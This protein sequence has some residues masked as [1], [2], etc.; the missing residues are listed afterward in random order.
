MGRDPRQARS[1]APTLGQS[2]SPSRRRVCR[3]ELTARYYI[4]LQ[5]Y[6]DTS[7]FARRGLRPTVGPTNRTP[8][9]RALESARAAG[10]TPA[11]HQLLLAIRGHGDPRNPTIGEVADHL[12]LH[13]NIAVDLIDRADAAGL[14]SRTRDEDDHRVV[15]L[16]LTGGRRS[17]RVPLRPSPRR[18]QTARSAPSGRLGR[19]WP[20]PTH[21]RLSGATLDSTGVARKPTSVEDDGADQDW[22]AISR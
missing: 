8:A 12:L 5:R 6:R 14:V 17:T 22:L 11:Q 20:C 16:H 7:E 13:H 15:R 18:A 9:L 10:L 19:P 4:V 21:P 1:P 3:R 2:K